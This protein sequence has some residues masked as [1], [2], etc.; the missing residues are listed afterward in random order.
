MDVS[1]VMET[2]RHPLTMRMLEVRALD[3]VTP[4]LMRVT[5]GGEDLDGFRSDGPADHVKVFFPDV[6][7]SVPDVPDL[8]PQGIVRDPERSDPYR[9]RD[10]TPR[11]RRLADGFLELDIVLHGGGVASGWAAR[12]QLGDVLGVAGPRGS[13]VLRAAPDALVLC[14]DETALPAID[15]WL[16]A[17][18]PGAAVV[19]LVETADDGERQQLTSDADI[20]V[21]WL[22]RDGVRAG[23]SHVLLDALRTVDRPQGDV[24]FWAAGEAGIVQTLRRHA[25]DT[26]GL[27]EDWVD[28]RG[29]WKLETANHQEPH[30]D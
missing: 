19:V 25:R 5:L 15:N 27:A 24:F 8:G 29:Y 7:R 18:P 1:A 30:T 3:R 28:T 16:Y 14:G 6:G 2:V 13:H 22:F 11:H 26:W 9:A 17:A 4:K 23:R 20:D 10:Y 12:A 21:R